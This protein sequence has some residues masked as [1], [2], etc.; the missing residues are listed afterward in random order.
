[1]NLTDFEVTPPYV[2]FRTVQREAAKL[3]VGVLSSEFV[4]L[5]PKQALAGHHDLR[6]AG[7]NEN[8]ILEN[9]LK[10]LRE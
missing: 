10:A 5:V 2:V 8:R 3:G 7:F 1:M 9:R 6:L 4:G